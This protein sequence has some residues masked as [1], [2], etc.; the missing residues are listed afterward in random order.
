M[1]AQEKKTI[2]GFNIIELLVVIAIIGLLS[3]IALPNI[4]SW[5]KE[6]KARLEVTKIKSLFTSIIAQVQKGTYAY[7][8]VHVMEMGDQ[9]IIDSRGMSMST[10]TDMMHDDASVFRRT[11]ATTTCPEWLPWDD[12]GGMMD[13]VT[14]MEVTSE[15]L[16]LNFQDS[17]GTV[18]FAKNPRW[19]GGGGEFQNTVGTESNVDSYFYICSRSGEA[20]E[21]CRVDDAEH[22]PIIDGHKNLFLIGWSRFGSVTMEKWS[23]SR[24]EWILQ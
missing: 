4:F 14:V 16:A 1:Q 13:L 9:V 3:G 23:A 20:S 17:I 5:N 22:R 8:Q 11:D 7:V 10:F 6:R 12:I 18:C 2:K 21:T 15:D 24:G 19:Y